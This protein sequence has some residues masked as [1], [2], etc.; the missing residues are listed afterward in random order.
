LLFLGCHLAA[1]SLLQLVVAPAQIPLWLQAN[2]F[3]TI[4]MHS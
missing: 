2:E 3:L 4:R 1:W